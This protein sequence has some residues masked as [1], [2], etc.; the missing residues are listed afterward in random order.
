MLESMIEMFNRS[1]KVAESW[2]N[3]EQNINL[4]EADFDHEDMDE[5]NNDK[6]HVSPDLDNNR[7]ENVE[8]KNP[9]KIAR[10]KTN[11]FSDMVKSVS[12]NHNQLQRQY[13]DSNQTRNLRVEM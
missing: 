9:Q 5:A 1:Y 10:N 2:K 12:P 7:T 8:I 4:F 11:D 13:T 3:L 6:E